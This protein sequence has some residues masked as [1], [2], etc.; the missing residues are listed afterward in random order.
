ML[1]LLLQLALLVLR[2]LGV[3]LLPLEHLDTVPA[4]I[5]HRNAR[6][7][8]VFRRYPRQ[9]AP[10]LLIQIWDRNADRLTLGLRIEPEPSFPDRFVYTLDQSAVPD[11]HRNHSRLWHADVGELVERRRTAVGGDGDGFEQARRRAAR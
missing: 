11:L 3:F 6:L 4:H 1:D 2:D 7:L 8:G 9:L 10:T 5:A